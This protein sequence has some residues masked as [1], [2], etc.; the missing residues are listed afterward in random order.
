MVNVKFFFYLY[1]VFII[2]IGID[3][4]FYFFKKVEKVVF[5]LQVLG[6]V[7]SMGFILELGG[8]NEC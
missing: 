3:L 7:E 5:G 2:N 1:V 8:L 4:E 6:V